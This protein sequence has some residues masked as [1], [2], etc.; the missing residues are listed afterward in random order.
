M[1][2]DDDD[3]DDDGDKRCLAMGEIRPKLGR[4]LVG[5]RLVSARGGTATAS[6]SAAIPLTLRRQVCI[7]STLAN[8]IKPI[9]NGITSCGSGSTSDVS[10][11]TCSVANAVYS[12]AFTATSSDG[13]AAARSMGAGVARAEA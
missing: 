11:A 5:V 10:Q 6:A 1:I 9:A 12:D 13:E 8:A 4:I 7:T 3:D 2:D